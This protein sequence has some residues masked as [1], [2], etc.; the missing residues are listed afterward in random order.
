MLSIEPNW[1]GALRN[2]LYFAPFLLNFASIGAGQRPNTAHSTAEKVLFDPENHQ[3]RAI[4]A[5]NQY[6]GAQNWHFLGFGGGQKSAPGGDPVFSG[7]PQIPLF[8]D[9]RP[10]NSGGGKYAPLN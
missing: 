5:Q 7:A 9:V 10:P 2:S 8:L 6:F 4:L 1:V 3:N